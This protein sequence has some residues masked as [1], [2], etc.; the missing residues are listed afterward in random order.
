M[1]ST[2]IVPGDLL[3]VVAGERVAADMR[4]VD[5][6]ECMFETTAVTGSDVKQK[7][8]AGASTNDYL[9]SPNMAFVGFLCVSG[10]RNGVPPPLQMRR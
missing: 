3:K 5:A 10:K 1:D 4:V 8:D 7:C 2:S 9:T 6:K